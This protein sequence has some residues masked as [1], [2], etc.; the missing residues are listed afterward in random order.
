M[1]YPLIC[2]V[3]AGCEPSETDY[4]R[5]CAGYGYYHGTLPFAQCVEREHANIRQQWEMIGASMASQPHT[6]TCTAIGGIVTCC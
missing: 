3:L 2:A 5:D 6:T 4:V 1:R